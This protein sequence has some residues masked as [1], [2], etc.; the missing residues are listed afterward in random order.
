MPEGSK[1]TT[2]REAEAERAGQ[3]VGVEVL[4]GQKIEKSRGVR[5]SG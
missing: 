1:A 3:S 4:K 2:V 5:K